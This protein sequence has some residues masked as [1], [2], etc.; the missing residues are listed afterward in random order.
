MSV[1]VTFVAHEKHCISFY[2]YN[3]DE[4]ELRNEEWIR[5]LI[6]VSKSWVIN[7]NARNC[8]FC[9]KTKHKSNRNGVEKKRQKGKLKFLST[10]ALFGIDFSE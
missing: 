6:Q 3:K 9:H 2:W 8:L 10:P 4:N 1:C 7:E 5:G